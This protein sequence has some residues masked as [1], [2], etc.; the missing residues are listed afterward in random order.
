MLAVPGVNEFVPQNL[1]VKPLRDETDKPRRILSTRL[2][3][4]WFQQD[5]SWRLPHADFYF[6]VRS[7]RANASARDSVLGDLYVDVVN[8]QLNEFSYPA[9]LAGLDYRLYRH[10]RGFSVR[11]SG[12]DE[13]QPRL[14]ARLTAALR[15]PVMDE[16][17]FAIARQ[18]LLRR[19]RNASKDTPYARAMDEL[20][21]LLLAPAWSNEERIAALEPLQLDD[22]RDYV[23]ALLARVQVVA[24]AHGNLL[25][26]DALDLAE[27]LRAGLLNSSEATEVARIGVVK[28]AAD[29]RFQRNME[30]D[31]ADAAVAVYFQGV[32]RDFAERARFMLLAQMLSAPFYNDL[33]TEKQLGYVVFATP[34]PLV[35][36]PGVAFVAQSPVA[37]VTRLASEVHRFLG[38]FST[39]LTDMSAEDFERDRA[40][41][42]ARVREED[43][44]L[45]D[46]SRRYW[47][48]LDREQFGF[49][50]RER[51]VEAVE[52][53]EKDSFAL[54]YRRALLGEARR[55]LSVLAQQ[56]AVGNAIADT[57]A[58]DD[59][60][61]FKAEH[62]TYT[63][64]ETV[65]PTA[66]AATDNQDA[67]APC[68]C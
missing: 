45:S 49:D 21:Y 20:G 26:S 59:V 57:R 40:A 14:L 41:V 54:F 47:A 32:G 39:R 56:A 68:D 64:G 9:M 63:Q 27:V 12:Y 42:V 7:P 50:T 5:S 8:E 28:L 30:V 67:L 15:T 58:L 35:E 43:T 25:D 52:Q 65:S 22:L 37:D 19:L 1:A 4:L 29:S 55:E 44:S 6:S 61:R 33:R 23:P 2:I 62:E 60:G 17:R 18:Q 51:V 11:M 3:E 36:V 10:S 24:L 66:R 13:Q 34:F 31:H 16:A 46:R 53:F 38:E 48:E